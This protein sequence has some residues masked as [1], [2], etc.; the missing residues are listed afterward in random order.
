M[1]NLPDFDECN[2]LPKGC[3]K[4]SAEEF[5]ERFV[6]V[7]G[8]ISRK[9][10]YEG[11]KEFSSRCSSTEA[12]LKHWV[13]GSY[14]TAKLNPGDIDLLVSFDGL[15]MNDD[16]IYDEFLELSDEIEMKE[17]YDCHVF[18]FAK[19]PP[20]MELLH[21][22][23]KKNIETYIRIWKM[24]KHHCSEEKGIIEFSKEE[25]DKIRGLKDE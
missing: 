5:K 16:A 24:D 11:Y 7:D 14:I 23:Y 12:V 1:D 10:I 18:C 2:C 6:E 25:I 8:S 3:H 17:Y 9:V 19:Y 22:N 20:D 13:N 21:R 4:P 15:K